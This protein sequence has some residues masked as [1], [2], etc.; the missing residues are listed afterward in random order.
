MYRTD[1][2]REKVS[3]RDALQQKS[4]GLL[5][6]G[7]VEGAGLLVQGEEGQVHGAPAGQG[8]PSN[9]S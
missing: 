8:H 7:D 3:H 5:T 1:G 4:I 6:A 2:A 9:K